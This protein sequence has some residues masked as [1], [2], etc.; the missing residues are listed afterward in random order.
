MNRHTVYTFHADPGHGWLEVPTAHLV[1]LG[2]EDRISACSYVKG[3]VAFLEED[4]DAARFA[5]AYQARFG[6]K[7][8]YRE[9]YEDP[10]PIRNYRRYA[11]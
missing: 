8:S 6:Q 2:I 11:A 5:E 3:N 7:I 9:V 1:E 4:C 10:T